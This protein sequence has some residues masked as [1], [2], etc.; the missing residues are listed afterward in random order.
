MRFGF[1]ASSV[2]CV[3]AIAACGG[4][5]SPKPG[6]PGTGGTSSGGG[7]GQGGTVFGVG[8]LDRPPPLEGCGNGELASNEAC[9]DGNND[10]GDGCAANCLSVDAGYSCN[11][12]GKPC[13][14]IARCGDGIVAPSEP[15]DDG[16]TADQDGCSA[17][18]RLELGHKCEG[19]PSVCSKTVCGDNNKEGTESCDDGNDM[20]F[21]GCSNDCQT[22]PD[23]SGG[24][25]TSECGDG[26]VIDEECDDGNATDGDG[27]SAS[28]TKEA[29]FEC[30]TATTGEC[31]K[32]GDT[33]VLRVPAIFRD[34]NASHSDFGV[35]CD[36]LQTG[37][38]EL[39]LNGA[40]KP[41]LAPGKADPDMNTTCVA[42]DDSFAEWYTDGDGRATIPGSI[43]LFQ[44]DD[45]GF[46]NRWGANGEQWLA[47]RGID[48]QGEP[49][50]QPRWCGPADTDACN[51][52]PA[53]APQPGEVCLDP[54]RAVNGV[55]WACRAIPVPF[56]GNPLF[57]PIDG[58]PDALNGTREAAEI[59]PLYG[60]NN[61]WVA[62]SLVIPGAGLHNFHF[63]T[64]VHYWFKYD[65]TK[66]ATLNF[67]GDDDVWVFLNGKR[68]VDLGGLHEPED[69]SVTV[70]ASSRATYGLEDGKVYRISVF[71]AERKVTG[72]SFKLTLSGFSTGR[73][74]C[75][76]ICGD[77]VVSLGE[78]CDDGVND[79][80]YG[81]CDPGCVLGPYCGDGITQAE[82]SCDDGNRLDGDSCGSSCRRL[83]V[84]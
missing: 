30:S 29:G 63:T 9:D 20:P 36:K 69:G 74:D 15:C 52:N 37:M 21:D 27:C 6:D 72:S 48:E 50:A 26:L 45:G 44:K 81:E 7:D 51:T 64:E 78:E 84:E 18:C 41:V 22:E 8:G 49:V 47:Y 60:N 68:A 35:K 53:C 71:H 83:D 66:S 80:G 1:L 4:E 76:A 59:P 61:S 2:V 3:V 79:G 23:C 10:D 24:A 17:R 57:F 32:I 39:A 40:G 34:F 31:E 12:P 28:C 82:E 73:S 70:D 13:H 75:T 54:C 14:V 77:Q 55:D 56:E 38:T 67:T 62:E 5:K 43:V 16:N 19:S 58:H 42:S 25:C 65:A 11:P 33:C 46:V